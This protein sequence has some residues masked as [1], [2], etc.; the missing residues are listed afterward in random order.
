MK[1][2]IAFNI[3]CNSLFTSDNRRQLDLAYVLTLNLLLNV[4]LIENTVSHRCII[5]NERSILVAFSDNCGYSLMVHQ[6]STSGNFL[7]VSCVVKF[8]ILSI[9]FI[10]SVTL[11]FT[12][13]HCT[14]NRFYPCMNVCHIV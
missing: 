6:N 9:N 11:K 1:I 8:Q 3:F 5:R 4:V 10:C 7:K 2:E 13:L 12:E 14:L